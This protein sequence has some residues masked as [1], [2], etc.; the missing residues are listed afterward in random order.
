MFPVLSPVR[1]SPAGVPRGEVCAAL[2]QPI[3]DLLV[4]LCAGL[5]TRESCPFRAVPSGRR[6]KEGGK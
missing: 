3:T 1:V 4:A 6:E 5:A 2:T